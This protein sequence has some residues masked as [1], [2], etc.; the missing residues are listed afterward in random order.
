MSFTLQPPSTIRI[1][2][3]FHVSQLEPDFPNTFEDREQPPPPPIIVDGTPEYLIERI[4]DS[5]YNRVRRCCQLL[6]HVKWVGYPI[7]NPRTGYSP[8]LSMMTPGRPSCQLITTSTRI[9][10][11]QKTHKGLGEPT[12]LVRHRATTIR[13]SKSSTTLQ[14]PDHSHQQSHPLPPPPSSSFPLRCHASAP[15]T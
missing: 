10:P 9:I 13:P 2:L 14:K 8:M 3:V 12:S 6:Y 4:I 1:H 7:S 15:P 5:K 11:A